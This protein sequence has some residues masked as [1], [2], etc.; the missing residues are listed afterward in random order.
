MRSKKPPVNLQEYL[1]TDRKALHKEKY[2][3]SLNDAIGNDP[4]KEIDDLKLNVGKFSLRTRIRKNPWLLTGIPASKALSWLYKIVFKEPKIYR[5]NKLLLNQ[6]QLF[7]FEYKNPKLKNTKQLPWFDKYPLVLSLGPIVTKQGVR[8][9]GFNLHLVPPKVRIIILCKIFDMYKKLYRYQIFYKKQGPVQIKYKFLVKPLLIYGAG[10]CVRMY[11][12]SRQR[13]IVI[14]PYI[15]WHKA[16][17]LPSRGYDGIKATK[18]I[19][20]WT[21]YVRSLGLGTTQ[22]VNWNNHI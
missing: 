3:K 11:I 19:Q 13:Q 20:A 21:K 22:N 1:N 9:I 12:P 4:T 8:N 10:F 18:L 7:T 17:F 2:K 15:D 5:H 6:G 14:F 16:I